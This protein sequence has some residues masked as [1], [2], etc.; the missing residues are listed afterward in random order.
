[1][2]FGVALAALLSLCLGYWQFNPRGRMRSAFY[3]MMLGTP[4]GVCVNCAAPV[5]KG[6]LRSRRIEM[7][8]ALMFASPTLNIV[9]LMMAFSLLPLYMA[10]TKL[11][12]NLTVILIGVPLLAR[13]LEVAPVKDLQQLETRLAGQSCAA[14]VRATSADSSPRPRRGSPAA[15]AC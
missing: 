11:V 1:M 13:W 6:A 3:G 5:F 8:L 9:V 12:F 2:A 10:V 4:L 7:A 15:T 14:P